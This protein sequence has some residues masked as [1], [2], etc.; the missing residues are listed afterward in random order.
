MS[1]P[2][3]SKRGNAPRGTASREQSAGAGS[4]P[5]RALSYAL[6][7]LLASALLFL[8]EP[9]AAKRILPLLGGS[10]AVWAACLVFFQTALLGGYLA[11]HW[12][13]T[14]LPMRRQRAVYL[15]LIA[16]S[17]AQ[18]AVSSRMQ[19][20]ADSSHPIAS[21]LR[22]LLV[23]IA[24]PFV[25]LSSSGPLLQS[26]YARATT[27]SPYRLYVV[28]NIGS[29]LGLVVYPWLI[30]PRASLRAQFL[31]LFVGM[32]V[33]GVVGLVVARGVPMIDRERGSDAD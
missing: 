24:L 29:L 11:A 3:E 27:A 21:V 19:L 9:I 20:S 14:R 33:F 6:A 15:A 5:A 8:L 16:A 31:G 2:A 10:A 23:L 28:S 22:L 26:W 12:L 30:E 17:I 13:A 4:W 1:R 18:L 25:T 32:I 7:I